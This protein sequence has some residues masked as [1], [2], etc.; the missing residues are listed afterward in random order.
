MTPGGIIP[1]WGAASS[2]YRGAALSRNRGAASSGISRPL[3]CTIRRGLVDERLVL[4]EAVP[5]RSQ[6]K[7][8]LS[9]SV[10]RGI[11]TPAILPFSAR[12]DTQG[13]VRQRSLQFEGLRRISQQPQSVSP[14]AR[15][16][17]FSTEKL[18]G[19][20]RRRAETGDDQLDA[21]EAA[22]AQADEEVLPR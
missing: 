18:G 13:V 12:D 5:D 9:T 6:R 22:F 7:H 2:R 1:L 20:P 4:T 11:L 21:V 17:A 14:A 10:E 3:D 15:K 16:R 19:L 8:W